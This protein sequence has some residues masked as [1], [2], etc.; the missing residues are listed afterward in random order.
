MS[1]F[2]S[3]GK[4]RGILKDHGIC[5]ECGRHFELDPNKPVASCK[6]GKVPWV[7]SLSPYMKLKRQVMDLDRVIYLQRKHISNLQNENRQ[8]WERRQ[9]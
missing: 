4:L 6:C 3:L 7:G 5:H 2:E 9:R 1:V 8:L